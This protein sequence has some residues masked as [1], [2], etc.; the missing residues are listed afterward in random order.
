MTFL[1]YVFECWNIHVGGLDTKCAVSASPNY[2]KWQVIKDREMLASS[3]LER[4]RD[5]IIVTETLRE[6]E[7][8]VIEFKM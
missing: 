1:V 2:F 3:L 7:T 5:K 6:R 8:F 4:E